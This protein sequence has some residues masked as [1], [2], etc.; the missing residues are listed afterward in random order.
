MRIILTLIASLAVSA[1]QPSESSGRA[2][3]CDRL[4]GWEVVDADTKRAVTRPEICAHSQPDAL[5]FRSVLVSTKLT[6]REFW[7]LFPPSDPHLRAN[8]LTGWDL[9]VRPYGFAHE[10]FL[11]RKEGARPQPAI[12]QNA[13]PRKAVGLGGVEGG[14]TYCLTN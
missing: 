14:K 1:C 13:C 11:V 4:I 2:S 12:A 3:F 10:F 9:Q 5:W 6:G 8:V 7:L